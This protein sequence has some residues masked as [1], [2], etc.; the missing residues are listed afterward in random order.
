MQMSPDLLWE[1]IQLNQQYLTNGMSWLDEESCMRQQELKAM[2]TA[3]CRTQHSPLTSQP[4][5]PS[6]P[7]AAAEATRSPAC[8]PPPPSSSPPPPPQPR[9]A[10]TPT[11]VARSHGPSLHH[12]HLSH[13]ECLRLQL[14]SAREVVA[15]IGSV[16]GLQEW[17]TVMEVDGVA[18]VAGATL[19]PAL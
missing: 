15:A 4:A 7:W 3:D 6:Q 11:P 5:P 13:E 8:H 19:P 16:G 10:P 14:S 18:I 12:V 2:L 9:S 17:D 1:L